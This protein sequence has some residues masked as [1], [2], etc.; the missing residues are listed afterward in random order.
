MIQRLN[1]ATLSAKLA[2]IALTLS[3]AS[4]PAPAA[5]RA[6]GVALARGAFRVD[7]AIVHSS[8]SVFD[9]STVETVD[10]ST[11]VRMMQGARADLDRN[12]RLR[13]YEDRLVVP[14]GSGRVR[15]QAAS[16]AVRVENAQ[17]VLLARVFPGRSL[18]FDASAVRD[19]SL[20]R[21]AGTL[22]RVDGRYQITDETSQT[23]FEILAQGPAGARLKALVGQRVAV[24]GRLTPE[25]KVKV[26]DVVKAGTAAAAAGAA[27]GTTAAA[28]GTA[29]TA[30]VATGLAAGTKV[31]IAGVVIA[32]ASA[33]ATV[34][35]VAAGDSTISQ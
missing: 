2:L 3:A 30:A 11:Q 33:G 29:T 21:V 35:V 13:V 10:V 25:M 27:A 9:G 26:E 31:I 24:T 32:A 12:S 1:P 18:L 20:T 23:S 17:G 7:H 14:A 34:G 15:V 22:E 8:A 28:T 6:I 5:D 19:R 16:E 4:V